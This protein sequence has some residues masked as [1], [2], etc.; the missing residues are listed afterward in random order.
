MMRVAAFVAIVNDRA[1]ARA[2]RSRARRSACSIGRSTRARET[3]CI[4]FARSFASTRAIAS[5]AQTLLLVRRVSSKAIA[6][7]V[8]ALVTAWSVC[9]RADSLSIE[10]LEERTWPAA[11]AAL[12]NDR[13]SEGRVVHVVVRENDGT[14]VHCG[15]YSIGLDQAAADAF[16]VEGCDPATDSTA[17]RL[18]HRA[19]LFEHGD[20]VPKPRAPR[21]V[22]SRTQTGEAAG[23]AK[24]GAE[25]AV[26]CAVRVRPFIRDLENGGRVD[27][28]PGRYS[29]GARSSDVR[30]KP[31]EDGWTLSAPRGSHT[32]VDYFV[33]DL[34]TSTVV[35]EDHVTMDCS[36]QAAAASGMTVP[37]VEMITKPYEQAPEPDA[38]P[39]SQH[40]TVYG[41]WQ[42]HAFTANVA[43]GSAVMRPSSVAFANNAGGTDAG[44]LGLHD[45]AGPLLVVSGAYERP[46]VYASMGGM[47]A[48]TTTGGRTLWNFGATSVIAAALHLGDT[49]LYLGPSVVL[50]TYQASSTSSETIAYGSKL[51]FTLG[52]AVGARFH[53][54][55]ER[56]GRVDY[57]FGAEVVAPAVG[58]GPWL[59]TAQLA[60]GTGT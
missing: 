6:L 41:P 11:V 13:G 14:R 43:L 25:S 60:W 42:G 48:A 29:L 21:I 58:P 51:D 52:G 50:G 15:T 9:A 17:V 2:E 36:V 46:G 19:A 26:D 8:F 35:L 20:I 32:S 54:R 23:G 1:K 4:A 10:T 28:L 34:K 27:L 30:A 31:T 57:V 3:P 49:S 44:A 7:L 47:V 39:P 5:V 53:V 16:A 37:R 56:T 24:N 33:T 12:Q 45:S 18:V 59:L 38:P 22:A 55:D 40:R